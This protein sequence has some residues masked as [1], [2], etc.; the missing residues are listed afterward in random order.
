MN[1]IS[2]KKNNKS[3]IY[4]MRKNE[5]KLKRNI[6]MPFYYMSVISMISISLI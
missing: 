3:A 4:K 1:F 5:F 6:T 2:Y